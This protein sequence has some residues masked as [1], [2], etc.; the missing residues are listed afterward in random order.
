MTSRFFSQAFSG[1]A[2][3]GG[4]AESSDEAGVTKKGWICFVLSDVFCR[5]LSRDSGC[6]Q[7]PPGV[8][9]GRLM[10][11]VSALASALT[12]SLGLQAHF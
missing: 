12:C 7:E 4:W 6:G 1:L 11:P 5:D 9:E 3:V 2:Q 8:A 10:V